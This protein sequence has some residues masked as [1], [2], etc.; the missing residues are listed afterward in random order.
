MTQSWP[1]GHTRSK[2]QCCSAAIR[3]WGTATRHGAKRPSLHSVSMCILMCFPI[4]LRP[5]ADVL[6]PA[7]TSWESE[8]LKTSFGRKGCAPG[9]AA[10]AQLRKA[11][12]APLHNTRS[13]LAVIFDLA[14]RL[15]LAEHF[16]DGDVE[17][18]WRH[19]LQPS[20]LT[21]AQ[22]RA[23]PVGTKA[24]L[25]TH[26]RKYA[27][28]DPS[29]GKPRGFPTPSR[30]LEL[31]SAR[32]AEAGYDPLPCHNEP[33]ESPIG[34]P[35]LASDYPLVLTS[36]RLLQFVDQQHRN[37]PRLRKEV[38][39]PLSRFIRK[40]RGGLRVLDG[41]WVNVE[42]VAGKVRLKA[43]YN[44]ALDP[45]VVCAPY[46]WWQAYGELGLPGYDPPSSAGA[47]I[48][49]IIP[50]THIDPISASVPHRS[51]MC[52]VTKAV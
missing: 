49:S 2:P 10:W 43:K 27:G 38:Q 22:L 46:G 29:A 52:R 15:G 13:D 34:M 24:E 17:A 26:Y 37:I 35:G 20:G 12:V 11:V 42:T 4:R 7:S 6:L 41:E 39:E 28:L 23:N 25:T 50:N 45:R 33:A 21:L 47:N 18:A 5:F 30:K 48:N 1:G 19:E 16:F 9:A 8:T 44:D 40:R 31:Y 14:C 3:C 51:R 36:F 32:F